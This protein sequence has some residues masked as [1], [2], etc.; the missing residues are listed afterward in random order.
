MLQ[1]M[2]SEGIYASL[3]FRHEG[4][5]RQA[6]VQDGWVEVSLSHPAWCWACCMD[7]VELRRD[8]GYRNT[9]TLSEGPSHIY[10]SP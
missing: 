8:S 5:L 6:T 3:V 4:I 2:L 7:H 10:Q 1:R 9:V